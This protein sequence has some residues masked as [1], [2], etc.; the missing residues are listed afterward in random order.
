MNSNQ[1]GERLPWYGEHFV[2]K[3]SHT[4]ADI[5]IEA[6]TC[7][8]FRIIHELAEQFRYNGLQVF[9]PHANE[10]KIKAIRGLIRRNRI[11]V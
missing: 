11:L 5:V 7:M 10:S 8:Q 9:D 2:V 3:P 6:Y 4:E 1:S